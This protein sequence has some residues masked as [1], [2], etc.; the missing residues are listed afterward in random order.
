MAEEVDGVTRRRRIV[1]KMTELA[2]AGE[3]RA[4]E[5]LTDREEGRPR[6]AI[7]HS[8]SIDQSDH[9]YERVAGKLVRHILTGTNGRGDAGVDSGTPANGAHS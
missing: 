8:G 6:Q 9:D 1:Q 3:I 7:E 5:Y 4:A 2:E